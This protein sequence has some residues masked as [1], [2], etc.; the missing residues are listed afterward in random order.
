[1]WVVGQ[2]KTGKGRKEEQTTSVPAH[3]IHLPRVDSL[4]PLQQEENHMSTNQEP[5]KPGVL[6]RCT[7][8]IGKR[9]KEV[10]EN[11]GYSIN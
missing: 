1:M 3:A 9:K 6:I 10:A 8:A 7:A 4:W 11:G 5:A 2:R